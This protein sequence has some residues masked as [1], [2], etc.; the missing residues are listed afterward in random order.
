MRKNMRSESEKY[1]KAFKSNFNKL[2]TLYIED[3]SNNANSYVAIYSD[4][5][6]YCEQKELNGLLSI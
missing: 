5:K 1:K 2:C 3:E 6:D 4:I